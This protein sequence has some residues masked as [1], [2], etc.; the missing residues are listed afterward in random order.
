MSQV[1]LSVLKDDWEKGLD[2]LREVL[3]RPGF[4]DEIVEVVQQQA[5][6]ALQRQGEDA[7]KVAFRESLVWHFKGHPY[8]RD[9]LLGIETIPSI[10][11]D[12]LQGFL[13]SY[14]VA[15]NMVIAVSG[16]ISRPAVEGGIKKLL[17]TLPVG[18]APSRDIEPPQS[19]PA[20]LTLIHKPGQVQS[21]VVMAL[22]GIQRTAPDF[23]KLRLLTDLFGG[24]DSLMYTRLRDD[25]GLVYSAG[26][27]ETYKWSAGSLIGAAFYPKEGWKMVARSRV[28]GSGFG[29]QHFTSHGFAG[30][31]DWSLGC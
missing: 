19:T 10:E 26:F 31:A 23:W 5:V 21:Q 17:A 11:R 27:F 16:D 20:V 9:P 15:E 3:T 6:T 12:D 25:L 24:S 2:L 18:P 1:Q 7:Q 14:F 30:L 8:G 28:R 4:D 22:P 29:V 13:Q